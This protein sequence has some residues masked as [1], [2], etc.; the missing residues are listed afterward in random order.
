MLSDIYSYP[1]I[2]LLFITDFTESFANK[3]LK[4]IINYSKEKEQ[5]SICRM[6]S[7]Y[8]KAIGIPG[9]LK[10]AQDW[11]V[12]AV[13]GR[14]EE[15]DNIDIIK[16]KGIIVI[17]QDFK[18]RFRNIPNITADYIGTG[19][20]AARYYID[21]GFRNFGFFGLNDVCWSDE[22]CEG[23]Q[24]EIKAAGFGDSFYKYNM[25][26]IDHHWYYEREKLTRWIK[27]LPKPIAIMACD[28]NQGNNL[29]EACNSAG[30]RIPSE[31]SIIGVDN[32]DL[33]CNLSIPTLS[34]I[35]VDIEE[36]GYRTAQMI[37][38]L[39]A[40]P[41]A[42]HE[43]IV[44]KPIRVV[45]RL[46]TAAYATDDKEIQKAVLFIHQ[47]CQRKI[48][49][50]DVVKVVALSRRLLEIRF[51]E[52]TGQSIWQYI[53]GLK[54]KTFAE[55]LL[56]TNEQI[57]NIALSLGESDAKSIS[58]KFKAAYGCSPNEWRARHSSYEDIV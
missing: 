37:E 39:V 40:N 5:W 49:V 20:M 21:R 17:A 7:Y 22:R 43:D 24:K 19:R 42:V 44:L 25:Q 1:M 29:I 55:M 41:D 56:D 18:K 46:S 51:K 54:L 10:W 31:V 58:K 4:G 30:I 50:D 47:N 53:S 23:F 52:V 11:E 26:D 35:S 48:S 36:G 45:G 6:P 33:L 13:I 9:I 27:E 3:L 32:D 16:E 12:D 2:R 8:K 28:D 34:S 38:H 14:F 15:N 57:I